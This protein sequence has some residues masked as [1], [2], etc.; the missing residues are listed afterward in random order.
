[1]GNVFSHR[2]WAK[3]VVVNERRVI[4]RRVALVL[5]SLSDDN[6][7]I[8]APRGQ[9]AELVDNEMDFLRS[10]GALRGKSLVYV[11][12]YFGPSGSELVMR[13]TMPEVEP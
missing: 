11:D 3:A 6:G 4:P 10:L 12:H 5:L 13:L 9:V 8:C 7:H 2:D 1:M